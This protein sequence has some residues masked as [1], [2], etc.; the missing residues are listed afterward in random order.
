MSAL[1]SWQRIGIHYQASQAAAVDRRG[2]ETRPARPA[3]VR[4]TGWL[5]GS[6]TTSDPAQLRQQAALILAAADA[7]AAQ[8]LADAGHQPP[9]DPDQ[10]QLALDERTS[11]A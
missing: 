4:L 1:E 9:H 11:A 2:H 5:G 3:A 10:L 6:F 7:L 8:Q